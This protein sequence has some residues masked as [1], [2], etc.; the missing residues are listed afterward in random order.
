MTNRWTNEEDAFLLT[1][2]SGVNA[3]F[4][5]EHDLGRPWGAGSRRMKKL[6]KTGARAAFARMMFC[7]AEFEMLAGRGG[8]DP[9]G[10]MRRWEQEENEAISIMAGEAA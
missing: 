4:I 7:V 2:Q 6:N 9:E 3:D 10:E 1:Y 5:A 8:Y